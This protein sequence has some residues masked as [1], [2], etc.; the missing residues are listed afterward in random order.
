[1]SMSKVDK[2]SLST[3]SP[4]ISS[5]PVEKPRLKWPIKTLIEVLPILYALSAIFTYA[6]VKT[7]VSLVTP[8]QEVLGGVPLWV[9]VLMG[10]VAIV[11]FS[12]WIWIIYVFSRAPVAPDGSDEY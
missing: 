1:M 10:L 4:S 11:G 3:S 9:A 8:L 2:N 6:A 5:K 12:G 7:D